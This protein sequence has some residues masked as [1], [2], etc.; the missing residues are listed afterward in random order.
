MPSEAHPCHAVYMDSVGTVVFKFSGR[1]LQRMGSAGNPVVLQTFRH[2][3]D[4][5]SFKVLD[6]VEALYLSG[7][8]E[9]VFFTSIEQHTESSLPMQLVHVSPL[10][11]ALVVCY[12]EL[13]RKGFHVQWKG[14]GSNILTITRDEG[15]STTKPCMV[16]L[17]EDMYCTAPE[18]CNPSDGTGLL[19]VVDGDVAVF[20]D[21]I[22]SA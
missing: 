2:I 4:V 10:V 19:A 8:N 22:T 21:T 5:T 13:R 15:E 1:M 20:M 16:V 7:R 11:Q 6:D 18:G 14:C 3:P 9:I 17:S 12:K